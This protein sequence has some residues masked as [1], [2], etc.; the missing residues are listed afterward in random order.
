MYAGSVIHFK[1][2]LEDF[3]TEDFD[4]EYS[5]KNRFQYMGNGITRREDNGHDLAWYMQK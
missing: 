2:M 3:R 1:E 5:S 4:F